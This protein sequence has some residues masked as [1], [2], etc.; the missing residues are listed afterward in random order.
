MGLLVAMSKRKSK[1]IWKGQSV[2]FYRGRATWLSGLPYRTYRPGL[3]CVVALVMILLQHFS[4][5]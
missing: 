5:R 4:T 1:S 3:A 2:L